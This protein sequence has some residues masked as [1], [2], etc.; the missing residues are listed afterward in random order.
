MSRPWEIYLSRLEEKAPG[1][2]YSAHTVVFRNFLAVCPECVAP[3]VVRETGRPPFDAQFD[4]M[5]SP[6][7]G[8]SFA[9]F[10]QAALAFLQQEGVPHQET[11][12][13]SL[14]RAFTVMKDWP[15]AELEALCVLG[16]LGQ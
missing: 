2:Y 5:R 4:L 1:W 7:A 13:I 9:V 3:I 6:V 16:A 10:L 14:R 15:A 12:A 11:D 8:V